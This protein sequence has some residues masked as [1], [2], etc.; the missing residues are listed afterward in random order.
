M[1]R[2][3][4][5]FDMDGTLVDSMPVWSDVALEYLDS[6][7]IAK[8]YQTPELLERI[9]TCTVPDTAVLFRQWFSINESVDSIV[10]EV[11]R[12]MSQ[13]Y[14]QD[15]PLKSGVDIYLKRL[16]DNGVRMCVASAT[17]PVLID[18]CLTRLGVRKYFDFLISCEEVGKSKDHPDVYIKAAHRLGA[19]G[20]QDTAVYEDA[21]C[22]SKTAKDA[23]FYVVGVY[24]SCG[25]R[26]WPQL[27]Q[28]ADEAITDWSATAEQY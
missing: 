13:H 5:I 14:R 21:L 26:E 27:S 28:L 22:A 10:A 3:Y 4:A 25:V 11:Y 16:S 12:I 2:K 17:T 23:G 19:P 7:G 1:D 8:E 20:P 6:R 9:K 24:D 18:A 15:I